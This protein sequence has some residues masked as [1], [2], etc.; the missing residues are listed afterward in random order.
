MTSS[1]DV[2][3]FRGPGFEFVV[4]AGC[5]NHTKAGGVASMYL[6]PLLTNHA[7]MFFYVRLLRRAIDIQEVHPIILPQRLA[8]KKTGKGDRT[9]LGVG[10][11]EE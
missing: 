7:P 5:D 1:Y 9:R 6:G 3:E 8:L 11:V 2:A 10:I 4:P